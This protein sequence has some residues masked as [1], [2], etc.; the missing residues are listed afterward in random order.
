MLIPI[1]ACAP[2]YDTQILYACIMQLYYVMQC[3]Y[4]AERPVC[5]VTSEASCDDSSV[6]VVFIALFA[7]A[8]VLI[9]VVIIYLV[10][11]LKKSS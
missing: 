7:I 10:I 4:I 1:L 9:T 2:F 11:Q 8:V 3:L 6:S 5:E